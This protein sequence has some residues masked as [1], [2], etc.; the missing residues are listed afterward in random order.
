MDLQ[1][2]H[3][4]YPKALIA[5]HP[6]PERDLSRMMVLNRK[7][8]QCSHATIQDLPNVFQEGDLLIFNDTKVIPA[9]LLGSVEVL[10]SRSVEVLLLENRKNRW[11]CLVKPARK[12]DEGMCISFSDNFSGK[13]LSRQNG[14]FEI[15]LMGKNIEGQI[16]R[17]GLPPLPPYIQRKT[18]ADYTPEDKSRYQSIFA[19]HTGSAAAPTASLHFS[20]PLMEKLKTLKIDTATITLHVS[21]DTFLPIRTEKIEDH[22]MHGERFWVPQE[23]QEKIATT[24]KR[25]GRVIAVGTTV[26]R[27]LESNWNQPSTD[28]FITPGFCF[29]IV[30]ALITNFHQ[31]ESTLIVLVSAFA[32]R[33]F[34]LEAYREAIRQKY[35]LFSFG[36]CMLV[37]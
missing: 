6:L 5:Q 9:R 33:E 17:H 25:G 13:I 26:V 37:L 28:L 31:P 16:E 29:K 1:G 32:G 14:F 19:R 18:R 21:S 2:F 4:E 11:R 3:Y 8:K 30:D 20:K 23:T 35:R 36:D 7:T 34:I 27:A 24:K 10:K 22:K 15:E 12:I